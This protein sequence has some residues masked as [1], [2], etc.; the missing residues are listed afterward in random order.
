MDR[1]FFRKPYVIR[2]GSGRERTI[3]VNTLGDPVAITVPGI[4]PTSIGYD[5][6]GRVVFLQQGSGTDQRKAS[7]RYGTAGPVAGY[8]VS[9]TDPMGRE[10]IFERDMLG[11]VTREIRPDGRQILYTWDAEG[12][13]ASIVP[14][15]RPPHLF[16]Y[17]PKGQMEAYV[18]PSVSSTDPSTRYTFD[19]DGLLT[20]VIR[21]DGLSITFAYN[22][23][24][25]LTQMTLPKGVYSYQYGNDYKLK[26]V[27]TFDGN[28]LDYEY[29]GSLLRNMRWSGN[30]T[31]D[32]GYQYLNETLD[33][34]R[35]C[36]NTTSCISYAYDQDGLLMQS[37]DMV[38]RRNDQNGQILGVALGGVE[39][40]YLY[41]TFA[42]QT[43]QITDHGV[44]SSSLSVNA[45]SV[46]TTD[47]VN[48]SGQVTNASRVTI[49]D[50]E[51]NVDAT[52]KVTGTVPLVSGYQ[53][54]Q[55]KVFDDAGN[56][57]ATG[58]AVIERMDSTWTGLRNLRLL[59]KDVSANLYLEA[60]DDTGAESLWQWNAGSGLQRIQNF[61]ANVI[62]MDSDA[63][64][65][66]YIVD[67]DY[68]VWKVNNG[69]SSLYTTI[70]NI[71]MNDFAVSDSGTL[72]ISEGDSIYR[73]DGSAWQTFTKLAP[74]NGS[75]NS[76]TSAGEILYASTTYGNILRV[77]SDGTVQTVQFEVYPVSVDA[78][79]NGTVCW[80]TSSDSGFL[81]EVPTAGEPG[82]NCQDATGS[83]TNYPVPSNLVVQG[84]AVTE[85]GEIYIVGNDNLYRYDAGSW[86]AQ[87]DSTGPVS[88]TL[89]LNGTVPL[90]INYE[91]RYERDK[92][93]RIT[94]KTET[95]Q[96][97]THV[98]DYAYD[99]SDRLVEVK[100]DGVTTASYQYDANGNR[101]HVNG[102]PVA[103]Y[104]S[105]DRLLTY[106]GASYTHTENGELLTKTQNGATTTYDYD[107]LGNLRKVVLPGDVTIEYVIDGQN[108][109]I[110]KKV[111]G[112][113]VQGFLYKDQLNPI[114]EL[115]GA[116]NVVSR[117]VYAHKA[118]VPAYMIKIDPA[119]GTE[120]TYRILSDHLGSPRL[121]VD[122]ATG[123][124]VQRID[125]DEWGNVLRDTNPGFQPFGFAGGI[126]D[127][128]TGLVRFGA[129]DYDP[130][131]GRWTSKDPILFGGG[132]VNLYG[133]VVNNPVSHADPMGLWS[134]T[135]GGYSGAGGEISFGRDE[136]TGQGFM[137]FK[138]GF[139]IGGGLSLDLLG[140]RPGSSSDE[141]CQSGGVGLGVYGDISF[142]AGP[143]QAG[144]QNNLGRN[145]P[146]QGDSKPYG[147]FMSP[148]FSV[149]D[150]GGIRASGAVGGQ[151]TIYSGR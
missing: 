8:L 55:V 75:F 39:T 145:F 40:T 21:P 84:L 59:D 34:S 135:F 119:T 62:R 73:Y 12:R 4:A 142:N 27:Q 99:L 2:S 67:V 79:A 30:I 94:R 146:T 46:V 123:E 65:N 98:W 112:M 19:L 35:I 78:T 36:V 137:S 58:S 116:G 56:I 105:Q 108:R 53:Y 61:P 28:T 139:G 18:P 121:V 103:T 60:T 114:A 37:G 76:I 118:N 136:N 14:P 23:G 120:K 100:R 95:I 129:R 5:N 17:L 13:L 122:V 117:F 33:I 16:S 91:T 141:L 49:N 86:V 115:D 70:D 133:Y 147:Q 87:I 54:L 52:G 125:Y 72:Y 77:A 48:V 150:S 97:E 149:G 63:A 92:L 22:Q 29:D 113:L 47:T 96:G 11:R 7:F 10:T 106:N 20:S 89:T 15:G 45:T 127:L 110:G 128:H 126:Y 32:V 43:E 134:I 102:Q 148:S 151:I 64:G 66:L 107:V 9:M 25:K 6:A 68:N 111:N 69:A 41:N 85:T 82:V 93:G 3:D 144:L 140:G 38:L 90:R 74:G 26:T 44:G 81:A 124:K 130:E 80:L 42:E 24:G 109:R 88:G 51:M 143:L 104:D 57:A 101:T 138:F 131:T 50:Q 83:T 132:D 71:F 31:G 1:E